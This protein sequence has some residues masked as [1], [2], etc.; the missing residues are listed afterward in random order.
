[1]DFQIVWSDPAIESLR[2]IVEEV[3]GDNP[4]GAFD[5]GTKLVDRMEVTRRFP[6]AGPVY[7]SAEPLIVRCLTTDNYRLYYQIVQ[8]ARRVIVLAVRHCAR[9]QPVF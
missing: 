4:T 1:M 9:E 6:E 8:E 3:A 5:L 7:Q 2:L